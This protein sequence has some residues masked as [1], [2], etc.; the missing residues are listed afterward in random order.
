MKKNWISIVSLVLNVVLLVSVISLDRKLER[1]ED[2]LRG[3]IGH[4]EGEVRE[5]ANSIASRVESILADSAKLVA[6]FSVE[7]A[8]IDAERQVLMADMVLT[9]QQWAPDT[10]VVLH[11]FAGEAWTYAFPAVENGICRGR[12]ELPIRNGEPLRMEASVTTGGLTTREELGAWSDVSL[13]LPVQMRSWGG[14]APVYRDGYLSIGQHEAFPET[15]DGEEAQVSDVCYRLYVNGRKVKEEPACENWL[16]ECAAGDE[17][18][19]TLFCR[20]AHRLGYE[21]TLM[22]FVCDESAGGSGTVNIDNHTPSP[23]LTWD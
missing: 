22:E 11:A 17:V 2:N 6:D 19:L 5:S 12:V 21:F 23:V 4:V 14:T 13:L 20:D 1:T 3:W 9:L 10:S 15:P 18:R 8:G 7:P 16:Q